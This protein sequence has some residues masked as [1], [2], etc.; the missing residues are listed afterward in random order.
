MD[1]QVRVKLAMATSVGAFSR[2]HPSTDGSYVAVVDRLDGVIVRIEKLAEQQAGGQ[3]STQSAA[4]RRA[5]I[6]RQLQMGLLR[7]LVTTAAHADTEAPGIA[8]KFPT[9]NCNATHA[10]YRARAGD[11]LN[12]ARR[13]QELLVR[14]GLSETLLD[15]LEATLA[16][17]DASLRE[18]DDGKQTHV[19]ARAEMKALCDEITRL[20]GILD[21][22]NRYRFHNQPQLIVAWESA[23]H[24]AA[25]PQPKREEDAAPPLTLI[26]PDRESAA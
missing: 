26:I 13:H 16:E 22:F 15:D 5:D 2:A 8:E 21:G 14:H 11:L 1:R 6:R 4:A 25:A 9:P 19:A 24:V 18:S 10:V 3:A 17:F 7:H 20:V 12:Q 23:K